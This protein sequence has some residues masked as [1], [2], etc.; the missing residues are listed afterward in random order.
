MRLTTIILQPRTKNATVGAV[1]GV[2]RVNPPRK[3]HAICVL[4]WRRHL[5]D[6]ALVVVDAGSTAAP[7]P[8][9][10]ARP[11]VLSRKCITA[12]SELDGGPQ[13]TLN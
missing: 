10:L 9:R 4:L 13:Q 3:L 6:L 11:A 12:L 8:D 7:C 2:R 5:A 1:M